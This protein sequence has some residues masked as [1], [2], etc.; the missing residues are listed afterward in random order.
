M[1]TGSA[2]TAILFFGLALAHSIAGETG[3]IRPLVGA[4]WTIEEVPRWAADRLLRTAWHLTSVAWLAMGVIAVG[5]SPMAAISVAAT[6]SG[7]M[8]LVGLAGHPAW[9]VFLIAGAA[10]LHSEALLPTAALTTAAVITIVALGALAALHVYWMAG[11]TWMFRAAVPTTESGEATFN[12]GR[13]MTG[14]VVVLL[15]VF[16]GLI[17]TIIAT[18]EPRPIRWLTAAG[19]GVL[20]VRAIGDNRHAGFTKKLRTTEFA[21]YD[22]RYFTPLVVLLAMGAGAALLI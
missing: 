5:G 19:I 21:D 4:D 20:A 16:A 15:V 22:D 17:L 8:M 9:P 2:V 6:V 18:D 12:P 11:G 7:L 14:A 1:E 3:F 10:G 13:W